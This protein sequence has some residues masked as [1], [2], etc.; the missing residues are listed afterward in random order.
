MGKRFLDAFKGA[1]LRGESLG[2]AL[3]NLSLD[4][5]DL[6]LN[7][8]KTGG[9]FGLFGKL[10]KLFGGGFFCLTGRPVTA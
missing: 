8:V 5:A 1:I 4:L 2:D 7:E 9:V 6:A 3:K 10:G